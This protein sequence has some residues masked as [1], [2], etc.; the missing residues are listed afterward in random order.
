[1]STTTRSARRPIS[2]SFTYYGQ[3]KIR[4]VKDGYETLNQMVTVP[5]PWYQIPPIDFFSENLVPAE[6]RDEREFSFNLA[7]QFVVPP[8]QLLGRADELRRG[9]HAATGTAPPSVRVGPPRSAPSGP[10]Y[11]PAPQ[12]SLGGQPVYPTQP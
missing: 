11:I 4:L 12:P 7:P 10:E 6:I 5:P 8:E 3:R 9:V 2:H 1:M